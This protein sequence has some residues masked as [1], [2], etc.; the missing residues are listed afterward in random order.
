M[1]IIS[2]SSCD[3]LTLQDAEFTAVPLEIYTDERRFVDDDNIDVHELLDYLEKYKGR[4]YTACPSS[5]CWLDAFQDSEEIYIVTMTSGL[6]GT[7]NSA[8][9]AK[10][11]YQETH[12]NA[13]ILIVDTLS[14]SAEQLLVIEKIRDLKREGKSFE[15]IEKEVSVYTKKTHLFFA[16][17]SLHNFAQNGR[18]PKL[19]A[20]AIG[21][22]G[23]SIIGMAS[24]EGK[25][26]PIG[27]CRGKKKV[28][29]NLISQLVNV[30]Y[31]G[32]RV[33]V[34]HVENRELADA[35]CEKLREQFPAAEVAIHPA[36]GLVAYY[37]ERGGMI[38][39]CECV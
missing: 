22:L 34:T 6:S 3:I 11:M 29:A 1:R 15:E 19:L 25:V 10:K 18:V 21:V 30:G 23:I 14:T 37:G 31:K 32:G 4:S 16:F 27:K 8:E 26:E 17:E 35:F 9:C 24:E 38:V 5:Q 12:P 2:D 20:Q 28:I 36:R 7:Y 13:K 39:G 33:N